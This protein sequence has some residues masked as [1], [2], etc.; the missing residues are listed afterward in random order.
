M[1]VPVIII[2]EVFYV[3]EIVDEYRLYGEVPRLRKE[4]KS[5]NLR[6]RGIYSSPIPTAKWI[7]VAVAVA[8]T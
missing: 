7:E 3:C 1:M 4:E 8:P 2:G 5:G 6:N